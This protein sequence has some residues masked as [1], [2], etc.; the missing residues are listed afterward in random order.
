M[1]T[2]AVKCYLIPLKIVNDTIF[3]FMP[4]D[5]NAVQFDSTSNGQW[6]IFS[7]DSTKLESVGIK[8][9]KRNGVGITFY[10]NGKIETKVNYKNGEL[11]G[12]YISF[13]KDGKVCREGN[14]KKFAVNG[15]GF[16]GN[17]YQYWD[18]GNMA[19]KVKYKN[20][21]YTLFKGEKYWDKDGHVT[22]WNYYS[23]HWYDC[24]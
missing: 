6:N 24:K 18:N 17:E 11:N 5:C 8:N 14:Y 13:Y 15:N 23:K 2:P 12:N 1:K 16:N 9:G 20:G 3:T 19:H 21:G 10:K 7:A 22:D 4:A